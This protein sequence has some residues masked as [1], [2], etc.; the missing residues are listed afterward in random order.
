MGSGR[1][2]SPMCDMRR[3]ETMVSPTVRMAAQATHFL[4]VATQANEP[5]LYWG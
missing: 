4:W 1:N 3:Q 2:P 5:P